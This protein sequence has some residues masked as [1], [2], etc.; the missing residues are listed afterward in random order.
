MTKYALI[1]DIHSNIE[2][3]DAV[4]AHAAAQGADRHI[5]LGDLVGYGPDPVA[6]LERIQQGLAR[7]DLAVLGNHDNA[8]ALNLAGTMNE[9][10]QQSVLWTRAQLDVP[11]LR[12][13]A[14][15]PLLLQEDDMTWVHASAAAPENWTYIYDG[16]AAARSLRVAGTH[17]VFSGHVHDPAIY[18][19]GEQGC[20]SP[21]RPR[22]DVAIPLPSHRHWLAIVG[23]CGQ[24][25][26]GQ[27]GARYAL[28]DRARC[29]LSFFRVPY[30]YAT[31]AAKIRGAGLPERLARH[32]EGLA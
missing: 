25:R 23:S 2:A 17:W 5:Y 30:D 7:G 22:E 8:I 31:T 21:I 19:A 3:L 1:A 15:L 16:D 9:V 18:Y 29:R 32:V 13:L 6:V 4:L 14:D 27:V 10:A 12:F 20:F 28:F 11:Q 24:P 26:D